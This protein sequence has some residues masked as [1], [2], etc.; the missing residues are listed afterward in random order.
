MA[1]NTYRDNL[2]P[3]LQRQQGRSFR[4]TVLKQER[5]LLAFVKLKILIIPKN[6]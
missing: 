4:R 3:F 1:H 2:L 5:K 6:P